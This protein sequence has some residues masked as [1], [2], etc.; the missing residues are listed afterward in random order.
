MKAK[1]SCSV[2][3]FLAQRN[4]KCVVVFRFPIKSLFRTIFMM[5]SAVSFFVIQSS[6][7]HLTGSYEL[8]SL[9]L[10]QLLENCNEGTTTLK[11]VVCMHSTSLS[12]Y[13][14]VF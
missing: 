12:P 8:F 2:L 9:L 14:L 3:F 11:I 6:S 13:V 10:L 5:M 1:I 7:C 4:T